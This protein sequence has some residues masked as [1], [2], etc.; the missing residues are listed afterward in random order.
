[1]QVVSKPFDVDD[2]LAAVATASQRL[3]NL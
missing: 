3:S 1:V 2:F